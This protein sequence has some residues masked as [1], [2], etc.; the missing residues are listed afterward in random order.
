MAS[1]FE[2]VVT[3]VLAKLD[4]VIAEADQLNLSD[5]Q[6][7]EEKVNAIKDKVKAVAAPAKTESQPA[8][9][10]PATKKVSKK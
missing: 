6:P 2:V 10:K 9:A 1:R 7:I 4:A 3:N 5:I 8:V